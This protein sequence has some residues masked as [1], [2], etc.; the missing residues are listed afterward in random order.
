VFGVWQELGEPAVE[1]DLLVPNTEHRKLNTEH[2]RSMNKALWKKATSEGFWLLA[3]CALGLFLFC[4][5]RVWFIA[6]MEMSRFASIIGELWSDIEKFST[7]PLSHL[8]TYPGRIAVVFNEPL[9]VLIMTVWAV[10]RGSDVVSGEI[11]RGTMEMLLAQPTSRLQVLWSQAVVGVLGVLVLCAA[12]LAG[13][14]VGIHT[15]RIK[16]PPK[17]PTIKIPGVK[18]D[19]PLPFL[20]P[21]DA[22]PTYTPMSA[23]ADV[24][25]FI[26]AAVNLGALGLFLLAFTTLMS[27]WDRHRWRTIGIVA[28]AWV[29]MLVVK[30]IGMA[31]EEFQWMSYLSFFTPYSPEWA[32]YVGMNYPEATWQLTSLKGPSE[33]SYLTPL[34]YNLILL[35][36]AIGCY[37]AA[38]LIFAK[39][40]LPAPL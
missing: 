28:T 12:T 1:S 27:S 3:I 15:F 26:P 35:A 11:S 5:I 24:R 34:A 16:E 25:E 2:R 36:M 13:T 39:R 37:G 22:E 32:V 23:K 40:D 33:A 38:A 29:V 9:V 18:I 4:F 30:A 6:R 8:L 21:K 10:S 20:T 17:A 14:F 31:V 19:V 7:V